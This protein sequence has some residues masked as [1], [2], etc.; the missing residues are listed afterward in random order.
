I[1]YIESWRNDISKCVDAQALGL[2]AADACP[3]ANPDA[4]TRLDTRKF[5]NYDVITLTLRARP[6]EAEA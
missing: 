6:G 2:L 5:H 3:V 1:R 4:A